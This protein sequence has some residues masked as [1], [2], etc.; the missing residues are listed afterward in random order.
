MEAGMIFVSTCDTIGKIVKAITKQKYNYIG[1]F[2][3]SIPSDKTRVW[4]MDVFTSSFPD[5]LKENTFDEVSKSPLVTEIAIKKLKSKRTDEL[6]FRNIENFKLSIC[7]ALQDH[8][9]LDLENAIL[10]LFGH[11]CD[12]CQPESDC[13]K[14][15]CEISVN[16]L[17]NKVFSNFGILDQLKLNPEKVD[18]NSIYEDVIT[19]PIAYLAYKS[20]TITNIPHHKIPNIYSYLSEETHFEKLTII[21]NVDKENNAELVKKYDLLKSKTL[22]EIWETFLDLSESK[23]D[24]YISSVTNTGSSNNLIL[25][26]NS[27]FEKLFI[28]TSRLLNESTKSKKTRVET[29]VNDILE[30]VNPLREQINTLCSK[31]LKKLEL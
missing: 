24:F 15:W 23:K 17:V 12:V 31:N 30:S 2:V 27:N 5:W 4:L 25:K 7:N 14:S 13:K 8:N 28:I 18:N 11:K 16:D 29:D 22:A 1:F 6:T 21:P 19:N 10:K 20:F 9:S 26:L 3:N